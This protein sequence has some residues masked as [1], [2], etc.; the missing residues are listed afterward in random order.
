VT[1]VGDRSAALDVPGAERVSGYP[2]MTRAGHEL[3]FV[4][5]S[6][7]EGN[8]RLQGAVATLPGTAR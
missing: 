7:E 3:V 8:D 1:A 2:H 5:T 6:T 4:W